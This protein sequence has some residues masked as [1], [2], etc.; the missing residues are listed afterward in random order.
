MIFRFRDKDVQ[1]ECSGSGEPMVLLHG[2]LENLPMWE[3]A[4]NILEKRFTVIRIDLPGHGGTS[5]F[6]EV[7]SMEL[8][9][10]LVLTLLAELEIDTYRIMGHSMG[11]YVALAMLEEDPKRINSIILLN[12]TTISDSPSRI[13]NRKRALEVIPENPGLFIRT[14]IRNLFAE[15]NQKLLQNTI[16]KYQDTA[17]DMDL[18]GI[19][20]AIRGMMRRKDRTKILKDFQN[21]KYWICGKLDPVLPV[22][23]C[24]KYSEITQSQLFVLEGGHMSI[25]EDR[26]E[27]LKIMSFI[28]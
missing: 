28:E 7:H 23:Q 22:N 25:I 13:Q 16:E 2:F 8:M 24:V 11:G 3:P 5:S 9:A 17:L 18:E 4:L 19:L 14:S 1:Y 26:S 15:S 6:D 27:F 21:K 20:A 10:E 12:S